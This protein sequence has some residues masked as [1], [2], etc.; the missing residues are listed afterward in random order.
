MAYLKRELESSAQLFVKCPCCPRALQT[1]E[2][3]ELVGSGS[4]GFQVMDA[5]SEDVGKYQ[6]CMFFYITIH[7]YMYHFRR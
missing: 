6:S 5:R 1:K 7:N 3:G 2:V 4:R